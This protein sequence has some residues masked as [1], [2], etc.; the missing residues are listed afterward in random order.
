MARQF[1]EP[2]LVVASHNEGKVREIADLL[3]PFAL[4]IISA[5]ALELAEPEET[6]DTF[7]ANAL[8]KAEAAVA[9]DGQQK[10]GGKYAGHPHMNDITIIV[11]TW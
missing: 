1:T 2:R 7:V 4:D 10:E 5:T 3:A 8:L 9:A 11:C 6:G